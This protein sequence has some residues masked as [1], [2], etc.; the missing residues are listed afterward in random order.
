MDEN[1]TT[2]ITERLRSIF[3]WT[4]TAASARRPYFLVQ[5]GAAPGALIV[6]NQGVNRIG[7]ASE[8]TIQFNEVSVSRRHATLT[9]DG[10]SRAELR[11][12]GSTNGTLLNGVRLESHHPFAL[13]AE[14]RIQFGSEII[15][16]YVRPDA[17]DERFQQELFERAARDKLTGLYNRA[18][19]HEQIFSFG[20]CAAQKGLALAIMMLDIDHFKQ[21]NDSRGHDAGDRVL[22]AV[23]VVLQRSTRTEDLAARY[24]GEEFTAAFPTTSE[25][26]AAMR[27]EK[28]RRAI[29]ALEVR[30]DWGDLIP[31]TA[32]IGV[33]TSRRSE[34]IDVAGL[35]SAADQCL[36]K[37]KRAGRNR[38]ALGPASIPSECAAVET[39]MDF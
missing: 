11:D 16:K 19:F 35:I 4:P 8:N 14:D 20:Q 25:D 34:P 17:C 21:I 18:Y 33:V 39:T 6:L 12:E 31:V 3:A 30:D 23:A 15:V 1:G 2:H 5:G 28:I 10:D 26:H 37:A 7:R 29:E 38:V 24:G 36:Y 9:I 22:A 13:S 32:S 27:A